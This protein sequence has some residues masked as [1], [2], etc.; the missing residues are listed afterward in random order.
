MGERIVLGLGDNIDYEIEWDSSVFER[1]IGEF[2]VSDS[3]LRTD[4]PISST[5]DLVVSILGFL[6]SGPVESALSLRRRSSRFC[7]PLPVQGH[8]RG[9]Q[10]ARQSP[11]ESL[12][13]LRAAPGHDQRPREET[14]SVGQPLGL[15]Q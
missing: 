5:R 3:E 4:K 10:R 6:K 11:C 13:H 7:G 8:H 14:D 15:Q 12:E 9:N 1:L 2:G